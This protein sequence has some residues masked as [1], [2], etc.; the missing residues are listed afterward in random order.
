MG[1]PRKGQPSRRYHSALGI[2]LLVLSACIDAPDERPSLADYVIFP[3]G[4][5]VPVGIDGIKKGMTQAE[6]LSVLGPLYPVSHSADAE[7]MRPLIDIFPYPEDGTTKY[8]QVLY[9]EDGRVDWIRFG[10]QKTY[11]IE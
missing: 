3:D 2:V 8:I 1:S 7:P 6:V 9:Q 11:A 4:A 10:H 5:T